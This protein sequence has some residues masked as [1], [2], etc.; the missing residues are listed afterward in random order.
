[1]T[2]KDKQALGNWLRGY[3]EAQGK[4]IRHEHLRQQLGLTKSVYHLAMHGAA[5]DE[6]MR[7]VEA[8]KIQVESK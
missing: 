3:Y 1:M 4:E 7:K 5:N 8:F 6:N 2:I